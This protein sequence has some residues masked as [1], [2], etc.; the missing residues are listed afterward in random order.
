MVH[1]VEM[2]VVLSRSGPESGPDLAGEG[3]ESPSKV[4]G[5]C[6]VLRKVNLRRINYFARST[7]SK[8]P[9]FNLAQGKTLARIVRA[10]EDEQCTRVDL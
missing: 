4:F 9:V 7:S 6:R 5:L 3:L 1:L 8:T 2:C 10:N